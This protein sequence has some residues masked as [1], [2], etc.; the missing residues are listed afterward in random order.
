MWAT[1]SQPGVA[2]LSAFNQKQCNA[3]V[4]YPECAVAPHTSKSTPIFKF[5]AMRVLIKSEIPAWSFSAPVQE[6]CVDTV[7]SVS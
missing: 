6:Y 7:E 4:L 3:Q 2:F 1:A 5:P